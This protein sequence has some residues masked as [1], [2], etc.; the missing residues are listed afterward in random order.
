MTPR[1]PPS[2]PPSP[3]ELWLKWG[4]L[5]CS[6][7][8]AIAGIGFYFT[9]TLEVAPRQWIGSSLLKIA[10]VGVL[11]WVAWP[12]LRMLRNQRLGM[13][14]VIMGIFCLLAFLIRPK[15]LLALGPIA[16]A[17]L[18]SMLVYQWIRRNLLS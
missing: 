13:S 8:A 11:T 12:Q 18:G 14:S 17:S 3:T 16:L 15:L 1:T 7:L 10:I 4:T 2:S 6:I 5:G 9:E